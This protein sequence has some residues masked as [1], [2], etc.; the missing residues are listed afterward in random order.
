VRLCDHVRVFT[1][2]RYRLTASAFLP[3]AAAVGVEGRI[4]AVIEDRVPDSDPDVLVAFTD[5]VTLMFTMAAESATEAR[6]AGRAIALRVLSGASPVAVDAVEL[7]TP[8][9]VAV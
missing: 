3:G 9:P 6:A 2:S 4:R 8:P 5:E 1:T 7:L